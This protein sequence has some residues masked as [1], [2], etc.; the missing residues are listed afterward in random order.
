MSQSDDELD[1]VLELVHD[2]ETFLLGTGVQQR[3]ATGRL[4]AAFESV[5]ALCGHLVCRQKL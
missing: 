2:E 3:V 5:A 1:D 4:C